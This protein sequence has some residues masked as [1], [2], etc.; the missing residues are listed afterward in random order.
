MS[1][2][3][4]RPLGRGRR[5]AL[6]V[7]RWNE[8]VTSRL[9]D[10]ARDALLGAG[11]EAEDLVTCRV[12]GSFELPLACHR[13]ASSGRYHAVVALGAV[14]RGDTDHYD[15]I[16]RAAAD[17][18]LRAGLDTGV[19]VLFGVLTCHDEDQALARAGGTHGNKGADVALDALRMADLLERLDAEGAR[20]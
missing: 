19:P 7:S 9:A 10:G 13:L 2:V 1:I 14:I 12:P 20:R 11:V 16:C 5:I 8:H 17:G 4:G 6:V 18:L 3:E 15:H